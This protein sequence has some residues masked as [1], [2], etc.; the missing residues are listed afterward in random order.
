[1]SKPDIPMTPTITDQDIAD[2]LLENPEFL[3]ERPALLAQ[4]ELAH[5]GGSGTTSLVE[6]QVAILRER[7]MTMRHR[8]DQ[9]LETARRN[10]QLF[11]KTRKLTIALLIANNN[12]EIVT[13]LLNSFDKDFVIEQSQLIL[14]TDTNTNINTNAKTQSDKRV[15]F[16]SAESLAEQMPSLSAKLKIFCGQLTDK[17]KAVLF[18]DNAEH[19]QSAAVVPLLAGQQRL[20]VL[21]IGNKDP[22]YYRSSMDTLFLSHIGDIFSYSL[23]DA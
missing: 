7:N 5:V 17:E 3:A 6:R 8:L 16:L 11:E 14:F 10:D 2:Y 4:I 15:R 20:G 1:M 19:V 23:F 21:A 9:L 18:Q 13:A 22:Q 12:T